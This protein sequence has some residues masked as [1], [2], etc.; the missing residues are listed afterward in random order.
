MHISYEETLQLKLK[1]LNELLNTIPNHSIQSSIT[2]APKQFH[3]RNN[4]QVHINKYMQRG[5]FSP[6]TYR[7]IA[8][9]ESGCQIFNQKIFDAN[10]PEPLKLERCVR[11]RID[12]NTD[13]AKIWALYSKEDKT[14]TFDYHIKYPKNSLTKVTLPNLNFFQVN[15][16]FYTIMVRE[17]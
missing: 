13:T 14:D 8:F 11:S 6:M 15:T 10:F 4:V 7:T 12:E 5:F 9:P 17:N 3:Y 1:W 2:P 16:S